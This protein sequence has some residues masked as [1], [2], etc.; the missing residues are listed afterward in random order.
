[1]KNRYW[2]ISIV[3]VLLTCLLLVYYFYDVERT[4]RIEEITGYQKIHVKQAA[5]NFYELIDKWNNVLFYLSHNDNIIVMNDNGVKELNRLLGVFKNEIRGI[6]RTSKTG[7]ITFTVPFYPNSIGAD[8]SRQKHMVKI[9]SDH[10]PVMSDVF[11]TVQGFQAIVIHY[12]VIR[13]GRFDG[14]I[15]F[16]LDFG[17]IAKTILDEIKIGNSG[18]AWMLSSE[19][20]E[21]YCPIPGHTGKSIRETAQGYP[22]LLNLYE[23]MLSGKEGSATYSYTLSPDNTEEGRKI[24][25]FI[26]IKIADTFWSLAITY[27]E[28]EITDSIA[29]FRNKLIGIFTFILLGGIG[30]SYFG[31]KGWVIVKETEARKIAE[32]ELHESELRYRILFEHNPAPMLI[33]ER[34]TMKMLAVN[35]AFEKHYGYSHDEALAMVLTD[36]YPDDEKKSIADV[37]SGLQ[38]YKNVGEWHHRR[39][40]GSYLSI[41]AC[42]NDLVY[43]G[44]NARVAVITDI[45][46]RKLAEE[47]IR[48]INVELEKR[49]AERTAK[50]EVAYSDLESFS[51]SISH[52]LRAP[53]RA[54]SGFAEIVSRRHKNSLN[55]E[56]QHYIDNIVQASKRMGH[57]IDDLLSYS[58]LGRR[59]VRLS[60]VSLQDALKDVMRNFESQLTETGATLEISPDFPS[61]MGDK[62]LLYQIFTNLVQNALIY[63]QPGKPARVG[64][65]WKTEGTS[66]VVSV[67]DNG[68][69]IPLEYQGKIFNVFQRLHGDDT[70][71]GTGIGLSTVKK[72]VEILAG[73]IRVESEVGKGSTFSVS[74]NKE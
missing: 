38:G 5:R 52:D 60:M 40:D 19:G 57:L 18:Y 35:E 34:G 13:N 47:K 63:H 50:L 59:S 8:I 53:L 23:S 56:G 24:A 39:R 1:M 2:F 37:V 4:R 51:Y 27:S 64:V 17:K 29:D 43:E 7:R 62:S 20:V 66:V 71:P 11:T 28:A 55:Q 9:L 74:L 25:Y 41:V 73:T 58:R 26:P 68:I 61:V 67:S 10:Q 42:S 6:T 33:Y 65:H 15:A 32:D 36:L 70:Y 22:D 72:G 12:P 14:T 44:K 49:V 46:E 69:G 45:T 48:T 3:V 54:I 21:L 31:I 16:L 30:L